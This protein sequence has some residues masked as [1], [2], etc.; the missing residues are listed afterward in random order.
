M[1][2]NNEGGPQGDYA[3][4]RKMIMRTSQVNRA[5]NGFGGDGAIGTTYQQTFGNA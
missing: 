1:N 5:A 4:E 2:A 3:G